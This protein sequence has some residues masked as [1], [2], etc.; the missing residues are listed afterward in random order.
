MRG[1]IAGIIYFSKS[2]PFS[3]FRGILYTIVENY[4][5]NVFYV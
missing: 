1:H 5:Y 4:N 2:P 3:L